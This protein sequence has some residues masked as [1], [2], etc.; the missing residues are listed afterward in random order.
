MALLTQTRPAR[1]ERN[2][3]YAG[4]LGWGA[5]LVD[6]RRALNPRRTVWD[7]AALVTETY[8]WQARTGLPADGVI[9]PATW[10]YLRVAAGLDKDPAISAQLPAQGPGFY[11]DGRR[12]RQFARSETIR[13]LLAAAQG[14]HRS[15]PDG[16][17]IGIREISLR[18]GGPISGHGSHRL[19]LDVDIRPVRA[20]GQEA[21]ARWDR[22]GYAQSLTQE[23]VDRLRGNGVLPVHFVLF[24]DPGVRGVRQWA[25]HDDHL[26]VRFK[27]PETASPAAAGL[28]GTGRI[29]A[30]PA[31][32]APRARPPHRSPVAATTAPPG[33]P[34]GHTGVVTSLP[35]SAPPLGTLV[36]PHPFPPYRFLPDDLLWTARFLVGETGGRRDGPE[37]AAVVWAMLNR[38]ALLTR[39]RHP[40]F[41]AFLRACSPPLQPVLRNWRTTRRALRHADFVRT[42]GTFGPPA[43]PGMPRGQRARYLELQLRPWDQLPRAARSLAVRALTGALSNPVGA[44][45]EVG[46]TRQYFRDRFG[47]YPSPREWQA[48]TERFAADQGWRWIGPVPGLDQRGNAFFVRRRLA[49]LP[50]GAV[51]V[52]TP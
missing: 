14:W 32:A 16:P 29:A 3:A 21:P 41:H 38:Y 47:R 22:P 36:A 48:Y 5:R 42:G 40:T 43:P 52:R 24:N 45:T 13:A 50:P 8:R 26:H 31:P 34:D 28:P 2:R 4:T 10:A 27:P 17:R 7:D 11:A 12:D 30:P 6:V 25:G 19:G 18:G 20:D 1:A 35:T 39:D 49:S 51:R 44:A 23:L 46:S 37:Q 15:H 33:R 9:G